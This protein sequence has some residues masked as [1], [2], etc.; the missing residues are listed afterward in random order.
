MA[1]P[2]KITSPA[3]KRVKNAVRLRHSHH[4]KKLGRM[5]VEGRRNI[6]RALKAGV[7]VEELF[8]CERYVGDSAR[9]VQ[10]LAGQV[11]S[12]GGRVFAVSAN[13][14]GKMAYRGKPEGLLAVARTP[15]RHLAELPV[16]GEPLLVVAENLE[17]PGNLGAILRSADAAGA[18]GLILCD[19]CTDVTNPNVITASTGTVFCMPIAEASAEQTIVWL[20][21]N[22][23]RALAATPAGRSAYTEV[24]MT[25]PIALLV[26]SEHEGLSERLLRAADVHVA[27]PMKGAADSLNVAAAA[28]VLLFEA[29]RQR[30]P[31]DRGR[32]SWSA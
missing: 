25:G 5:I 22:G 23:I 14:F 1:T 26:G 2:T 13:V 7:V 28:T 9:T 4:R 10:Q 30:R 16:P 29:A 3:N 6:E 12:C 31:R 18:D 24:D 17:K 8:T 27:I 32:E 15:S 19:K 21:E 20:A 11:A